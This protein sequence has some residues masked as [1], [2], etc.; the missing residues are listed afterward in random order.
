VSWVADPVPAA[1]APIRPGRPQLV[2]YPDSLGG[3][4]AEI[5]ALLRGPLESAFSGVHVL[6]PFPSSGDRGFAPIT[7][8]SIDPRFGSWADIEELSRTHA[9]LLD[10]MVNHISR[11][12]PEFQAFL[13][14]GSA[15]PARELFLTPDSV[16]PDGVIP[17]EDLARLFL[18]RSTGPFSTFTAATG[19]RITVWTTFGE[20]DTSEQIDLDL[21]SPAGRALV[22]RWLAGLASHGVS[23]VRLDAVGYVVKQAGTSCFMVEPEI[24]DVLDRLS[25]DASE[26]GLLALPEV[27]GVPATHQRITAHGHWTYDFVLPALVMHALT[28]GE[29]G[30]LAAHLAAS[31]DRQVTT[32]DSHDGIPISP[33]LSGILDADEMR[34]LADLAVQRGG[35]INPILSPSHAVGG[36]GVHQLNITYFSALA[37]DEDRYLAARAIQLFARGIPQV[38]YVGLLAGVNDLRAVA[39]SGEGRAINRHDFCRGEIDDALGRPV[40]QRVLALIRLRDSHPAFGGELTIETA[41]DSL[42]MR[43]ELGASGCELEADLRQGTCRVRWTDDA[44][45]WRDEPG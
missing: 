3:S 31:P 35:N 29:V 28:T 33:D 39:A 15:S 44:G 6:P 43:W 10:V 16:W 5:T 25:A 36:V 14:E 9:V 30:R 38:Y 18:R 24:F 21:R 8:D 11:H 17:D 2:T 41:G 26:H 32:L 7:Y 42:R 4:I 37:E 45:R 13:R 12:S 40:V 34:A 27:H 23:M 20:G 19:E 1:R 22:R